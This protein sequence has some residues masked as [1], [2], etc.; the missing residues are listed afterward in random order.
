MEKPSKESQ[1]R[2]HE[3]QN[4]ELLGLSMNE[5]AGLSVDKLTGNKTAITMVIHYYKQLADENT[6]LKND[7]NTL[8]S[9][10]DGYTNKKTYAQI[11]AVLLVLSNI[12]SGV[13]INLLTTENNWPGIA[14]LG[15][16]LLLAGVGIY[17][18]FKDGR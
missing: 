8:K 2:P 6:S 10:V 15:S 3:S 18:S 16:G 14:T 13:G 11:S 4:P 9:Y 1:E 7:L 5:L 12:L 17:Y